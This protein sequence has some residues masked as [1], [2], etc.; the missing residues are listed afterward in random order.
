MSAI[1]LG[2]GWQLTTE[3]GHATTDSHVAYVTDSGEGVDIDEESA[4]LA[5]HIE[6]MGNFM[7]D[8]APTTYESNGMVPKQHFG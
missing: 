4:L 8:S 7:I 5:A 1:V 3:S 2:A 6:D